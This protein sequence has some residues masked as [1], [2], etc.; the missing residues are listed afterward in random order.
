MEE[1]QVKTYRRKRE[2]YRLGQNNPY[3]LTEEVK[4]KLISER[5]FFRFVEDYFHI[6]KDSVYRYVKFNDPALTQ[7]GFLQEL[8]MKINLCNSPDVPLIDYMGLIE[9]A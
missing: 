4:R 8:A 6:A 7:I 2:S 9:K 1:S 3:K 5:E